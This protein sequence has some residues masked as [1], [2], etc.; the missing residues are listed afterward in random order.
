MVATNFISGLVSTLD[1]ASVIDQLMEVAHKRVD[2]LQ[3]RK[4]Q[5]EEKISAWQELNT[6]LLALYSQLDEL[7]GASDFDIFTFSL[8]SSSST[9]AGDL[10]GVDVLSAA[11]E[12]SH[13]IEVLST[14]QARRLSS[15]SFS[16]AEE[17]LGLEGDLVINGKGLSV[18]S[19]DTLYG[20]RDKVNALDAGVRASVVMISEGNYRLILTSETTGEEG[21]SIQDASSGDLLQQL[22]FADATVSLKHLVY[23]G[24]LSDL[25]SSTTEAIGDLLGLSNPQSGTVT[26]GG[27]SV[28]IDLSSDSLT[29][30]RD[31]MVAAGIDASI[32]STTVDGEVRYRL[33]VGETLLDQYRD[34]N[35]V[36]EALGILEGGQSDVA[37]VL[38]AQHSNT[39]TSAAGGG[40]IDASTLWSE[41]D[42]GGDSNNIANGDTITI[43]G[44][45]HDGT[46]VQATY[47]IND[48]ETDTVQGL[49][50]AIEDAFGGEVTA[51]VTSD[52]KIRVID[53]Q[54]GDSQLNLT[55]VANN[56]G[57]GSLQFG[58]VEVTTY[59][60]SMEVAAG[61]DAS[62][63]IDG[64]VVE[65]SSNTIED[66]IPGVR[67]NLKRA[68]AGT[69]ITLQISRD[70]EGIEEK[71]QDFI[72]K[73]ND[74]IT[75]IN[76]Q[77]YY[78]EETE[79]G[80]VL[81]GDGTLLSIQSR[82][83][84]I[85][86][87]TIEGLG[88]ERDSLALIGV[89]AD[90]N[91]LLSLDEEEF[92]EAMAED[93][94][95]VRGVFAAVGTTSDELLEYIAH[96]SSTQ[97]G[98]YTVEITQVAAQASVTGTEDLTSGI[99][100]DE[101]ITIAELGTGKEVEVTLSAGDTTSEIVNALNSAFSQEGMRVRAEN[102]G[103]HLKLIHLDYGSGHGF[104][105]SQTANYTGISDG[106]YQGV[107]VAGSIGGEEAEGNGQYLTG[108]DGAQHVAGLRIKYTGTS[109]GE[110]GTV[111]LTFGV[112]EQLYQALDG[113]TDPYTGQITVRTQGLQDRV[114]YLE[115][116]IEQM[117]ERLDKE[118]E[119]LVQQFV[120][121]ET[122]LSQLQTLSNWLSQQLL[123][124][125]R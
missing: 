61:R 120:A 12:G 47:T 72:E 97:A 39:K 117:E 6:K 52:G 46:E 89:T 9:D 44:T 50:D 18:Q 31:K 29:D 95:A 45:K 57:G 15:R 42:T 38:T 110:V 48:R 51:E 80:G 104:T 84:S 101:T 30:I 19:T 108:A 105:V 122:A 35:N 59:G 102:D 88:S 103:G 78:D 22:G 107:D 70:V 121:M 91:G 24:A 64:V 40:Y 96:T 119:M 93:W 17:A 90:R 3:E 124:S 28:T 75:Y 98:T 62:V 73:Y 27:N 74:I 14:A 123:A 68:E 49:L 83:R 66:A 77:Y 125:F 86:Y 25:F 67:L 58:E 54:G 94:E 34:D 81:M 7:R 26:V 33:K 85:V 43:I 16:S 113:I 32:E 8:S 23:D 4:G 10:L 76:Q 112:A 118:R 109:T 111:T 63:R 13:Q 60:Y 69:I 65:R 100:G 114:D 21:F 53:N 2:V 1:W 5:F 37:Q 99:A 82:I 55:L 11:Q 36:L 79:S 87:S 106:T 115:E 116:Q 92:E 56:E 71:V 20:L 41:I